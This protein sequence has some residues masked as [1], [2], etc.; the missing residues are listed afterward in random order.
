MH[1]PTLEETD[2]F[3]ADQDN[4]DL[5]ID[6]F[7]QADNV[8]TKV[9]DINHTINDQIYSTLDTNIIFDSEV[10]P[11]GITKQQFRKLVKTRAKQVENP[12]KFDEYIEK[13]ISKDEA[14]LVSSQV[15]IEKQKQ[16]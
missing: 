10:N 11:E 4:K 8:Q 16:F 3:Y 9:D 2:P 7:N 13:Q 6:I 12:D 5:M 14:N 15:V 1:I